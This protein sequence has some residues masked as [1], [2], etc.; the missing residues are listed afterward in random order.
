MKI[1]MVR[2]GQTNS[3]VAKIIM[4]QRVDEPLNDEGRSQAQKLSA[5]LRGVPFDVIFSSP[6][7]RAAETAAIIADGGAT[8][9]VLHDAL[10]ERDFGSLS[11]KSWDEADALTESEP[12][13]LKSVD[14]HLDYDYR[15]YGGESAEDVKKRL[16]KF[17]SDIKTKYSDKRILIVAHAGILRFSHALFH[18]TK[19]DHIRNATIEE[20]DV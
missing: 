2:H 11:G 3:N 5:S 9:I 15:P 20:F 19:V 14:R 1:F 13:D 4:G 8:H 18:D 17:V 16:Q 10:K 7:K 12:G 6:L